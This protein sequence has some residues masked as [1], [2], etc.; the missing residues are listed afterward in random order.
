MHQPALGPLGFVGFVLVVGVVVRKV[1]VG[2]IAQEQGFFGDSLAFSSF[3][4]QLF[5]VHW[6]SVWGILSYSMIIFF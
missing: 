6:P 5:H 1:S 2:C 4:F 3:Q